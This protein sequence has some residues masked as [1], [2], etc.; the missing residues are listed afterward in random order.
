LALTITSFLAMILEI[1]KY[2][3][4]GRQGCSILK[5]RIVVNTIT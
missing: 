3:I 1:F 4:Y 2:F 5:Q